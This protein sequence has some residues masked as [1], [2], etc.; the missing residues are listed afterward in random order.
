MRLAALVSGGKDS[1]Y[2][3]YLASKEHSIA[4]IVSIISE[5]PESYMFH[6]PNATLVAKQAESMQLP[7]IQKSTKGEKEKE[8][9]DLKNALVGIKDK[10]DGVVS[11]AVQSNY[12]KNRINKIC[13]DLNLISLAPLWHKEPAELLRSMLS[14][15]FEIIITAVAA[16]PLDESWLGRKIDEETIKELIKLNKQYGISIVGEGGEFETFVINCPLFKK[17]LKII[18]AK[19]QWDA[20]TKSGVLII[21]EVAL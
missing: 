12:Q 3:A 19:K 18:K 8:L 5:N 7:L 13:S 21:K 15:G 20:K 4:F 17:K 2:A 14:A 10:I 11:G 16:P 9:S 1:L 6:V